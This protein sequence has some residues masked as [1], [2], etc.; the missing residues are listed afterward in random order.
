MVSVEETRIRMATAMVAVGMSLSL[1]AIAWVPAAAADAKVTVDLSGACGSSTCSYGSTGE[2]TLDVGSGNGELAQ[3]GVESHDYCAIS[4]PAGGQCSTSISSQEYTKGTCVQA[5]GITD[6][7]QGQF[8][9]DQED[10]GE[11]DGSGGAD[12][13]DDIEV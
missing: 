7:D 9:F 5:E 4:G 11:C 10:N 12:L 6:G 3:T 13:F 8:A 2:H 1:I